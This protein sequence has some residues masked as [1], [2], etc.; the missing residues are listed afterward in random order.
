MS[1]ASGS[2]GFLVERKTAADFRASIV[3][4]RF[5]EQRSR[6]LESGF[7]V[8]YI[9]EGDLRAVDAGR[10]RELYSNVLTAMLHLE[11]RGCQVLR[12]YSTGETFELLSLLVAQRDK[13]PQG[14]PSPSSGV[15]P[16]RKSPVS[17]TDREAAPRMV[18]TRMLRCIPGMSERAAFALAETFGDSLPALQRALLEPNFPKVQIGGDKCLG[19]ARLKRLREHLCDSEPLTKKAWP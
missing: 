19:H 18:F 6:L 12:S 15:V 16:P 8:V 5:A 10:K 4:G 11:A 9:V 3:D 13:C 2:K 17:K 7:D 1:C 14:M